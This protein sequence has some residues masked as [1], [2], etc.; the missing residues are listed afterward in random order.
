A[1]FGHTPLRQIHLQ[2]EAYFEVAKDKNRPFVVETAKERVEVLGT[3]FNVNTYP[4]EPTSRTTLL[5]GSVRVNSSTVLVPGQQAIMGAGGDLRV[6]S[7]DTQQVIAWRM[8]KFV[9]ESEALESVMQKIGRWYNVEI[10][11]AGSVSNKT[12]SGTVS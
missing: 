5:E 4:D 1:D 7:V 9:F 2:G 3:H 6:I 11:Y 10:I 12:F 8:G